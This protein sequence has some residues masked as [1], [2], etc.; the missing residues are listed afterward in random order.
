MTTLHPQALASQI[1]LSP[2]PTRLAGFD[3]IM[4]YPKGEHFYFHS[5][6]RIFYEIKKLIEY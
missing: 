1:A 6:E 5:P 2:P 3:T 4:P